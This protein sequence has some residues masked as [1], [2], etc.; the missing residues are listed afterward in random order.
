ME[1]VLDML[2]SSRGLPQEQE[3]ARLLAE[4]IEQRAPRVV[5]DRKPISLVWGARSTH[6]LQ[7][8][9]KGQPIR[10]EVP[11]DLAQDLIASPDNKGL[12]ARLDLILRS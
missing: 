3:D 9:E 2:G 7:L 6:T 11:R 8:E 5:P 4:M 12:W 10:R 1:V